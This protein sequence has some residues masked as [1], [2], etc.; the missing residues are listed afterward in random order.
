MLNEEQIQSLAPKFRVIQILA[1]AILMGALMFTG[2]IFALADWN[3][4]D[5]N[6]KFLAVIGA[7]TGFSLL[8]LAWIVPSL[9]AGSTEQIARDVAVEPDDPNFDEQVADRFLAQMQTRQIVF[10]AI[11]EAAIF[12]NLIV[13]HLESSIL[14]LIVIGLAFAAMV[15]GFPGKSRLLARLEQ[16]INDVKRE[17][18]LMG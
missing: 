12:L 7:L 9:T 8:G 6:T 10:Y 16:Q 17:Q 13:F 15:I 4:V 18:Q 1:I 14:S 3:A 2:V 11:L 5:A